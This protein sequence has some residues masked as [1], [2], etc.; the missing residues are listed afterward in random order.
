MDL[1]TN[2]ITWS[3]VTRDLHEVDDDYEPTFETASKFHLPGEG[4]NVIRNAFNN[5]VQFGTPFDLELIL[6]T[7]RGR[8]IWCREVGRPEFI[9]GKCVRIYG[10][11][12]DIDAQKRTQIELQLSEEQFRN[13]FDLSGMGMALIAP[14]KIPKR[15]NKRLCEILGYTYEEFYSRTFLDIT[16]PDDR[17]TEIDFTGRLINREFEFYHRTK[18]Y[19]HKNGS[20]VWA[21]ITVSLVR[22]SD[23]HPVHFVCEI[24]DITE[25]KK[26]EDEKSR[27]ELILDRTNEA[28]RIGTWE[29]D[30]VAKTVTW[31]RMTRVI[32]DVPQDFQPSYDTSLDLFKEGENRQ[33]IQRVLRDAIENGTPF[34]IDLLL[35]TPSGREIWCRT[36]GQAEFKDGKCIRTYGLFQDIDSQKKTQLQLQL[37]EEQFRQ[38]FDLSG[39]G[40]ALLSLK[41]K[42]IRVNNKLCELLGYSIQ[43]LSQRSSLEVTYPEDV[44]EDIR[45]GWQMLN[46]EI[47]YYHRAKRFLHKNGSIVWANVTLSLVRDSAGEPVHFVCEIDDITE[48]KKAEDELMQVNE[49]LTALFNSGIRVSIISTDMKGAITHFSKGAEELF[50]YKAEEVVGI[51][52]PELIQVKGAIEKKAEEIN[53][54]FGTEVKGFDALVE[55]AR[56]EGYEAKE[57][58]YKRK[59]GS[60]FYAHTVVSPIHDANNKTIGF[61][62]ISTDITQVKEAEANI[63][64]Y[65]LL[66]VKNKEMEQFTFIAS[67]DLLEPLQTVS[68]FVELLEEEYHDQLDE[69]AEKYINFISAS[70]RRMMELVKGLLFYSRLGKARKLEHVDCNELVKNVIDDLGLMIAESKAE[71]K[72]GKLPTLNAYPV[73]LTQLF[74]NLIIN[75]IKF[76]KADMPLE[77]NIS[78]KKKY[79]KWTF[80]VTDNGIGIEDK[81]REKIFVIFQRLHDRHE[82]NG[83]GI[84]LAY[85]KKIAELHNGSIWVESTY[86]KGSTFYFTI[87]MEG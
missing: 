83:T 18:R 49:E 12:Q 41:G 74:Q 33:S 11:M 67:H 43:E 4:L 20:V 66:E 57:C 68:S 35:V 79:D 38:S 27:I 76:R 46:G 25:K 75:A 19:I 69:N 42:A 44:A 36:I 61:L 26:A 21:N 64:K 62:G 29:V 78:A 51:A 14:N 81:N 71:I 53:Q 16:H 65:A 34:D 73:E 3:K 5:A 39:M 63:R 55:G 80:A 54:K 6:V 17:Q 10:I 23:G 70:T 52:T 7:A 84:G 37:N 13:S 82:Y 86:G 40:M 9:D 59:D 1:I 22:D 48:K 56:Q 58:I 32:L 72:V 45:L 47:D 87:D 77:I 2:K 31:S 30:Q 28:A 85:C 50:G 60:T 8:E 24:E 15:V